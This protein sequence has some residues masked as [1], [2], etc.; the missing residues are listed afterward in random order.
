MAVAPKRRWYQFSLRTF[1]LAT[2]VIGGGLGLAL[3]LVAPAEARRRAA[4]R[5]TSRGGRVVYEEEAEKLEPRTWVANQLSR[6]LPREYWDQVAEVY[7]NGSEVTDDD[8][9]T[10]Q[11][12]PYLRIVD[13]QNTEITDAGVW[14][15]RG[16]KR[17]EMLQLFGTQTTSNGTRRFQSEVPKCEIFYR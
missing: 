4:L 6:W 9:R 14:H 11:A 7:M 8:L 15:L 16:L 10:L 3:G 1:L 12:L 17:L 2:A 13:L 5:V